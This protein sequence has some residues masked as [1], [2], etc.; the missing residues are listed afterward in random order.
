[1]DDEDEDQHYPAGFED[2]SDEDK[3]DYFIRPEDAL[4]V[5]GKVVPLRLFRRRSSPAWRST[6]TSRT[7]TTCTCTTR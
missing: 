1:M 6:S 7:A 3:E 4:V 5:A 2:L